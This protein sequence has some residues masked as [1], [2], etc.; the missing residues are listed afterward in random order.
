GG[1]NDAVA[2]HPGSLFQ[3][4]H[5][6]FAFYANYA[7]GTP[8]RA[9][10]LRDETDFM[11]ALSTNELPAVSFIKPYGQDNEHPG[12]ASELQGQQHVADLVNA[13]KASPYWADTAIIITYDEFGGRWDHVAPPVIDRWGPGTRVPAIIISPYA[14]KGFVDHTQYETVSIL[15]TIEQ[16]WDLAPLTSRDAAAASLINAFD[17]PAETPPPGMPTT[18]AGPAGLPLIGLLAGGGIVL[19]CAGLVLRRRRRASTI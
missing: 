5:Q 11:R 15:K 10:H 13:V 14:K 9:A 16:R 18:G 19:A 4:H 1:W 6:A 8:G 12:Y 7:D 3:A 17:F 2:G